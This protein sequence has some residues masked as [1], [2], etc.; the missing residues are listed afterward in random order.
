M[1]SFLIDVRREKKRE[2]SLPSIEVFQFCSPDD[3]TGMHSHHISLKK[4]HQF[5]SS[6]FLL[7]KGIASFREKVVRKESQWCLKTDSCKIRMT[8]QPGS[9]LINVFNVNYCRELESSVSLDPLSKNIYN[10]YCRMKYCV[11]CTV[12]VK[13][14]LKRELTSSSYT[15]CER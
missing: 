14:R 12:A 3:F 9:L 1:C 11:C 8:G 13:S 4:S 7:N 5:C 6:S 2:E 15:Y 10:K